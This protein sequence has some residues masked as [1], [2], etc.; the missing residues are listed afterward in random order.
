MTAQTLLKL[1]GLLYSGEME[2]KGSLEKDEVLYA[3]RQFGITNLVEGEKDA[4]GKGGE[5]KTQDGHFDRGQAA[6]DCPHL[7]TH[8]VSVGTQTQGAEENTADIPLSHSGQNH[9]PVTAPSSISGATRDGDSSR[10]WSSAPVASPASL[11]RDSDSQELT[12]CQQRGPTG[13]AIEPSNTERPEKS[14]AEL[15]ESS[16]EEP[17]Q[18]GDGPST[19]RDNQ[20]KMK[21]SFKV[22]DVTPTEM[23]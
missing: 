5:R 19:G 16:R 23:F 9:P 18:E 21:I 8:S 12:S 1:V 14:G 7:K 15:N 3:A 13:P 2:V 17:L 6:A 11:S 4:W 22:N 10:E 20:A